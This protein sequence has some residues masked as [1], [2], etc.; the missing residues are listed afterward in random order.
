[1]SCGVLVGCCKRWGGSVATAVGWGG[2][3]Y[4]LESARCHDASAW[5]RL[6]LMMISQSRMVLAITGIR[7]MEK[8]IMRAAARFVSAGTSRRWGLLREVRDVT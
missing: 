6:P 3:T 7:P 2:A 5:I 4:Q 8:M 1:M